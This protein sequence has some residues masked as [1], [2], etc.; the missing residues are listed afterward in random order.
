MKNILI[1]LFLCAAFAVA[2]NAT[3][4]TRGTIIT[5]LTQDQMTLAAIAK[6]DSSDQIQKL[7]V[8]AA[9]QRLKK[10]AASNQDIADLLLLLQT[11]NASLAAQ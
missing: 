11:L 6:L 7:K 9:I 1:I 8:A 10:S 5:P 2:Q 4:T 3:I